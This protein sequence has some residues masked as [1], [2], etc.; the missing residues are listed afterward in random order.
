M[1]ADSQLQELHLPPRPERYCQ[2]DCLG[3][4]LE[5][6]S[7]WAAAFSRLQ[8]RVPQQHVVRPGLRK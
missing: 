7:G 1:L 2:F 6:G 3:P 8:P 5:P 4:Q